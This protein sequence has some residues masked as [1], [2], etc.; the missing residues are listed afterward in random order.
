VPDIDNL[1][2]ASSEPTQIPDDDDGDNADGTSPRP[3]FG[4][5]AVA[6]FS[7]KLSS[8]GVGRMFDM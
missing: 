7:R 8:H 1:T 6:A 5:S 4:P 2:T 3:D